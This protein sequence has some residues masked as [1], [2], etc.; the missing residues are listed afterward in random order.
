MSWRA[1]VR[2]A[3]AV[4]G[5]WGFAPGQRGSQ[6]IYVGAVVVA[7]GV[8]GGRVCAPRGRRPSAAR[9]AGAR[10]ARPPGRGGREAPAPLEQVKTSFDTP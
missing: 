9:R 6:C 3:A 7:I 1:A 5:S 2:P 10:S 4:V 8:P